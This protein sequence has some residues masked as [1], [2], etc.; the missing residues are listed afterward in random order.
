M[1]TVPRWD[2]PPP[3]LMQYRQDHPSDATSPKAAAKAI[4][5]RFTV[6]DA[7]KATMS[8]LF[9]AQGALCA[10]CEQ[11]LVWTDDE[12]AATA[13]E[14]GTRGP[15]GA[16]VEL[17]SQI[18]HLLAKSVD[19]GRTLDPNNLIAC[20]AGGSAK[21]LAVTPERYAVATGKD[22]NISCGQMKDSA[23][24]PFDPRALPVSPP[25]LRVGLEGDVYADPVGCA[26]AGLSESVVN[27]AI[28]I[29]LNLNCARLTEARRVRHKKAR[30]LVEWLALHAHGARKPETQLAAWLN[31]TAADQLAPNESGHLQPFWSVWRQ[32]LSP[33]SER[34]IDANRAVLNLPPV[35]P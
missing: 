32:A 1:K 16:R 6:S 23:D 17:D 3:E 27:D 14:R 10:Y 11:S 5:G 35:L 34:W 4:W 15:T 33:F 31:S 18:E 30:E 2:A 28:N 9:A 25:L 8:S 7:Y 13:G 22:S 12:L 21:H 26:A 19:D 20:C 24:L 29:A